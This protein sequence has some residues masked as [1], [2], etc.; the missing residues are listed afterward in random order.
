MAEYGKAFGMEVIAW[1]QNLS[2]EAAAAV[3]VTRV[4]K[5]ELLERSDVLSIHVVLE[6]ADAGPHRRR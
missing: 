1:S 2:A 5:A 3:G 4:E 6:R